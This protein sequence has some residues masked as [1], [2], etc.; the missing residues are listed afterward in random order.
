M[1]R[2][3]ILIVEDNPVNRK[4]MTD[5]LSANDYGTIIAEDGLEGEEKAIEE[6]PDLI[7]MDVQLPKI[8]GY[9]VIRRLKANPITMEIPIIVV[10]SFAMKGEEKRAYEIGASGYV[11][12]PLD[13]HALLKELE[14]FFPKE[15]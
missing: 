10:T 2:A 4:L 6:Q 11:P 7:L 12:K 9:E 15:S 13:I 5:L 14:R 8:D 1:N 3:K